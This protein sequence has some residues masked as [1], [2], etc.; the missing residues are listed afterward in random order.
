MT[1]VRFLPT[2]SKP[3]RPARMVDDFTPDLI[4]VVELPR[5]VMYEVDRSVL[6]QHIV[7]VS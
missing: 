2:D 7:V 3:D 4:D 6:D 1:N 5:G